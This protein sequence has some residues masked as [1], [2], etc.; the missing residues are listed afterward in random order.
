MIMK[1]IL[2]LITSLAVV[3]GIYCLVGIVMA[4]WLSA[5]PDYSVDIA[6]HSFIKWLVGACLSFGTS[7]V[8]GCIIYKISKGSK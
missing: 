7:L 8:C 6:R 4:S 2:Y 1:I 5:T 3:A